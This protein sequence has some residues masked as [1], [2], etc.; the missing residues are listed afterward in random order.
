MMD[1]TLLGGDFKG[2]QR[3]LKMRNEDRRSSVRNPDDRLLFRHDKMTDDL[4]Q[5]LRSSIRNNGMLNEVVPAA[6]LYVEAAS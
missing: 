5:V 3:I 6:Q 2:S 1:L 4:F